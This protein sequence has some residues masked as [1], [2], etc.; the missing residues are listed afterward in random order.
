MKIFVITN[1]ERIKLLQFKKMRI[2]N[3]YKLDFTDN[4]LFVER[5][6]FDVCKYLLH[7]KKIKKE[8]YIDINNEYQIYLNQSKDYEKEDAYTKQYHHMVIEIMAIFNNYYHS[9]F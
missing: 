2:P 8:E 6:D 1:E 3:I 4:I 7:S 9:L 5:V